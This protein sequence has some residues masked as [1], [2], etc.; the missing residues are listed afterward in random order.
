MGLVFQCDIN[1]VGLSM[2]ING[3]GLFQC[4]INEVGLSM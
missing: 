1:V 3:V 4:D 2:D